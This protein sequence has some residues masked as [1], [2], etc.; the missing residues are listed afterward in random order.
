MVT[1]TGNSTSSISLQGTTSQEDLDPL[2]EI[3]NELS[4]LEAYSVPHK[5]T[6]ALS[7]QASNAPSSYIRPRD[8][9]VPN[10]GECAL[11]PNRQSNHAFLLVET[12]LCALLERI[13]YMNVTRRQER[14]WARIEHT[15]DVL[16]SY[17]ELEWN[18]QKSGEHRLSLCI[19]SGEN[20]E[21]E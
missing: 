11:A 8:I 9:S 6:F 7:P 20:V 16:I 12:R 21:F 3:E 17:K 14:L 13:K 10:S 15:L 2:L 19:N 5:L 18:S 4:I 1:A